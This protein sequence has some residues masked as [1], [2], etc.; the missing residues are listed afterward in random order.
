M[1]NAWTIQL[2]IPRVT[3]DRLEELRHRLKA[4]TKTD[5]IRK[6]LAFYDVVVRQRELGAKVF[7]GYPN[8]DVVEMDA[9]LKELD[10]GRLL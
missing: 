7:F 2:R 4:G 6:A 1:S 5:V 3:Y 10:D 9:D 8:G